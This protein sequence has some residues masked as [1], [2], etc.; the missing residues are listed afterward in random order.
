MVLVNWPVTVWSTFNNI[1]SLFY[2]QTALIV[3]RAI[4]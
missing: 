3:T 2:I 4:G 1:V